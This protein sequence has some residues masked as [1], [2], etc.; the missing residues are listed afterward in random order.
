[1]L[2][3]RLFLFKDTTPSDEKFPDGVLLSRSSTC[4]HCF[5]QEEQGS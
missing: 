2:W 1:M 3:W 5:I 4:V